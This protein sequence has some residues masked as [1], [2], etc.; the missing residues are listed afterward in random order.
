MN[1]KDEI[2]QRL[3]KILLE[4]KEILF[5][6]LH[7]SFLEE[8]KFNDI[9]AALY[10][11]DKI[12]AQISVVDFEISLS[13]KIE[14]IIKL[15]VDIK[16]L[17]KAPLAFKYQASCGYLLFSRDETKK[18]EFLCKT[19]SEYFDFLPLSRLYLNEVLNA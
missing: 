17:N 10:I 2:T 15:P 12:I 11:D 8:N 7:G 5:A 1:T 6:Y 19:W 14:K 13:L 4:E 18:E 3:K 9:D 16:L